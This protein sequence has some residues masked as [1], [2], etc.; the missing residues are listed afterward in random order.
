MTIPPNPLPQPT[1]INPPVLPDDS[2]HVEWD[3]PQKFPQEY[4]IGVQKGEYHIWIIGSLKYADRF[5]WLGGGQV[6]F[7]FYYDPSRGRGVDSFYR[8]HDPRYEYA[9]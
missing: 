1:N 3:V 2:V 7:C 9:N 6:G 4:V 5:G 8:C